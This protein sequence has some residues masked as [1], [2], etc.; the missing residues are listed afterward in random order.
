MGIG[1]TNWHSFVFFGTYKE[2]QVVQL[3]A[4]VGKGINEDYQESNSCVE[5]LKILFSST[6]ST[7]LVNEKIRHNEEGHYP[8]SYQAYD[9]SYEQYLNYLLI[10]ERLQTEKNRFYSYKPVRYYGDKVLLSYNDNSMFNEF[11]EADKSIKDQERIKTSFNR[12]SLWNTCRH[13]AIA[14]VETIQGR[15][16]SDHISSFFFFNLSGQTFLDFGSPTQTLPFYVLP[17]PPMPTEQLGIKYE[18]AKKLY[19]RLEDLLRVNPHSAETQRKF[20]LLKALYVQKVNA[21]AD[22][23]LQ[24]L[25]E[26]IVTWKNEHKE[27]LGVLRKTYFWDNLFSRKAASLALVE[28][29]E[30]DLQHHLASK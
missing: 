28:E 4:R 20:N 11:A 25:Y 8:I 1:K 6:P 12:F 24:T 17:K 9:I 2:N 27:T 16:F 19:Q 14:F 10:S 21:S 5:L 22:L 15:T 29:L 13:S 7:T 30:T 3:L 23:N 26:D 18:L